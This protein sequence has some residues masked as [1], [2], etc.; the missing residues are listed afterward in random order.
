MA[1]GTLLIIAVVYLYRMTMKLRG[2]TSEEVQEFL[3]GDGSVSM[4]T[5]RANNED[6]VTDET[7]L[8]RMGFLHEF[9]IAPDSYRIGTQFLGWKFLV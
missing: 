6:Y 3:E 9:R 7:I 1:P 5:I 2:L 8:Y 4:D